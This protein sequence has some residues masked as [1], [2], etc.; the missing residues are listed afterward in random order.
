MVLELGKAYLIDNV[1]RLA[2][3][4]YAQRVKSLCGVAQQQV[5]KGYTAYGIV[6]CI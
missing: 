4:P 3:K 2:Q 5:R 6:D 1:C